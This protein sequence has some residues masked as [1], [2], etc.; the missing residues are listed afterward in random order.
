VADGLDVCALRRRYGDAVA[1][2]VVA[3]LAPH[4]PER[5]TL[6]SRDGASLAPSAATAAP[7]A[8]HAARLTVP[9][10]FLLSNSVVSDVFAR[11][12]AAT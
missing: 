10:G 6:L 12:P 7:R 1:D 5:A 3:A 2:A 11:L 4:A 9:D 8:V